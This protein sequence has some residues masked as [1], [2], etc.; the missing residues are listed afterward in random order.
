[1]ASTLETLVVDEADLVLSFGFADD[2]RR[3]AAHLPKVV[4]TL[5]MSATLSAVRGRRGR[6]GLRISY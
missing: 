4:Q 1:V 3:L 5:L 6:A 2:V